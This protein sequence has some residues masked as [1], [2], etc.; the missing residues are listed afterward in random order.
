MTKEPATHM[1]KLELKVFYD[2]GNR[3]SLEDMKDRLARIIETAFDEGRVTGDSA[4]TV[5]DW[6]YRITES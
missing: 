2:L 3:E 6:N 5:E 4:A 1:L